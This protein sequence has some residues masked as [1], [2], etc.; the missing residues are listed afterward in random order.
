M[1]QV[2]FEL[3]PVSTMGS[4]LFPCHESLKESGI[5]TSPNHP[6]DPF[7]LALFTEDSDPNMGRVS[8]FDF[9]RMSTGILQLINNLL[10]RLRPFR[11]DLENEIL[12]KSENTIELNPFMK[13][14]VLNMDGC[15]SP[16]GAT[17]KSRSM[18]T[19]LFG[20]SRRGLWLATSLP[21]KPGG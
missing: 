6:Q 20:A 11:T 16:V 9:W 3:E 2:S 14:S 7:E 1:E 19:L 12:Q 15:C 10:S 8:L 13:V 18:D 5:P 17:G 21:R 4:W